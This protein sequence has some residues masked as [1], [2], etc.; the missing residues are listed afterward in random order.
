MAHIG[1][2]DKPGQQWHA[3]GGTG[4]TQQEAE[5]LTMPEKGE[6]LELGAWVGGWDG[7][8]RVYLCVWA[9]DLELLASVGPF[10]VSNQGAG[11]PAGSNVELVTGTLATPLRL[12]AG[13]VFYVGFDRHANDGHQISVGGLD[14]REH[15]EGRRGGTGAAWPGKLGGTTGVANVNRRSGAYVV[16]YAPI[17]GGKVYDGT[18]WIDAERVATYVGGSWQDVESVKVYNG[19]SWIDAE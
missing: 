12:D 19:S 1:N 17:A 8:C 13:D 11:G 2:P 3:Y 18:D 5:Q 14:G 9:S 16:D 6:L 10:T 15:Y 4:Y 7:T